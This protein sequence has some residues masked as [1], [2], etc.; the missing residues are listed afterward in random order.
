V[1]QTLTLSGANYV[2]IGVM[3]ESFDFPEHAELW[4][5]LQLSID[6]NDR[7]NDYNVIVQLKQDTSLEQAT[8]DMRIV[9][10]RLRKR[11]GDLQMAG[12]PKETGGV[13]RYHD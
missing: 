10:Q 12:G 3:P 4:T 9:A 7:A 6:P 8:A 11:F 5:P 1:G 2:I 13:F